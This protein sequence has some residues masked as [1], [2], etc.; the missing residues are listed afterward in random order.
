MHADSLGNAVNR[1][2]SPPM[3]VSKVYI[4]LMNVCIYA[5]RVDLPKKTG[6]LPFGRRVRNMWEVG[7]FEDYN[8]LADWN[9][10]NDSFKTDFQKSFLLDRIAEKRGLSKQSL[11]TEI[12]N[13]Q[14]F[15]DRLE[16]RSVKD[17]TEVANAIMSY[18]QH[19]T[20]APEV[21]TTEK[22]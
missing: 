1:L 14:K 21:T 7:G 6:G 15:L 16:R 4:P 2:T 5:A 18:Y 10:S 17:H 12:S 19:K 3:N 11:L 13:R 22:H 8:P 9:P 20:M